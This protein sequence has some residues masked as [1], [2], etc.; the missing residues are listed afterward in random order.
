M[1][2]R[3]IIIGPQGS[4]KGT[5]A[6]KLSLKYNIPH[7]STGDIFRENIK[8]KTSLGIMAEDII[9]QGKLVPDEITF[10]IVKKRLEEADC[11]NG[12]LLDGFPRNIAQADML[13][14]FSKTDFAINITI[15]DKEAIARISGR[16]T[17]ING[18]VYHVTLNPPKKT[19]V[20]D[21][22]LKPLFQRDDDKPEVIRKRLKTYHE[23][24]KPL[25][26]YY[27]NLEKAIDI[28]GEQPIEKVYKDIIKKLEK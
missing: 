3:L 6:K 13:E 10:E 14:S 16:R 21:I 28:N 24:T 1:N 17:C 8:Q 25:I 9:N 20:C 19:G 26:D 12:Y 4:G 15:K 27:A 22:D 23:K 2:M 18:H 11:Q 7:I 5:Q